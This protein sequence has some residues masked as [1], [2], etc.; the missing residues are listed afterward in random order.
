MIFTMNNEK[1][2]ES[3]VYD[4]CLGKKES[5]PDLSKFIEFGEEENT[6]PIEWKNHWNG[7]PEFT[8]EDNPP[9]KKLIISFRTKEDYDAFS[10][11]VS[12][13]LT[14]KT[15]SIWYP[16]LDRDLNSLKRWIED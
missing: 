3:N 7:M 6:E 10:E 4:N 1:I 5:A 15:K 13:K 11:L 12:Q 14:D 8:Q 2:E 9:F 16:K